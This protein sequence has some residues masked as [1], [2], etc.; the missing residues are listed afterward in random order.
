MGK[1]S[2][3]LNKEELKPAIH[4]FTKKVVAFEACFN[5][6]KSFFIKCTFLKIL[7]SINCD[8]EYLKIIG[9][10]NKKNQDA[11]FK[12]VLKNRSNRTTGYNL[13]IRA[14]PKS[15]HAFMMYRSSFLNT[16]NLG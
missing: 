14:D 3:R 9:I 11:F 7:D 4:S 16:I 2:F 10:M 6:K 13:Q 15:G 12:E 5:K 8:V 1:S